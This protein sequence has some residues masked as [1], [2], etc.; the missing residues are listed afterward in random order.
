MF[1]TNT[2]GVQFSNN[3][4]GYDA[5]DYSR[6]LNKSLPPKTLT[7]RTRVMKTPCPLSEPSQIS[8]KLTHES[9]S[10]LYRGFSPRASGIFV[11][12]WNILPTGTLIQINLRVASY[13][14]EL[15]VFGRVAFIKEE[16]ELSLDLPPGM[17]IEF[18]HV[19]QSIANLLANFARERDP[20]FFE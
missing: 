1:R 7:N 12:T 15:P 19:H 11:A 9:S 3:N 17:M 13:P 18:V 6:A 8:V 16:N 5:S 14:E 20:I 2:T 4:S 10:N